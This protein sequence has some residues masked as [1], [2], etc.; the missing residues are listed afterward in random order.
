[1]GLRP[2]LPGRGKAQPRLLSLPT[3]RKAEGGEGGMS[4]TPQGAGSPRAQQ[5]PWATSGPITV[6]S[7]SVAPPVAVETV[8][9]GPYKAW[10]PQTPSTEDTLTPNVS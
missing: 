2:S 9:H 3:K 10:S 1:M 5:G 4:S 6:H 7:L 8:T